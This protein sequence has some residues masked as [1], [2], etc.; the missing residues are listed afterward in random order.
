MVMLTCE[1]GSIG[2]FSSWLFVRK[3]YAS[4]KID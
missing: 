4:I 1:I 3:I 2:F